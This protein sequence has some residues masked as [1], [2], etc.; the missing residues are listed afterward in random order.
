VAEKGAIVAAVRE[1]VWPLTTDG[2]LTVVVD[3]RFPMAEAAGAHRLV[4][5]SGHVGKVLLVAQ[6]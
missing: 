5:S 3:R 4:E 2:T 1:H 6:N